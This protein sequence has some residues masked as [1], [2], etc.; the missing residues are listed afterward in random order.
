MSMSEKRPL[1]ISRGWIQAASIV[2][3]IGFMRSPYETFILGFCRG[4][5]IRAISTASPSSRLPISDSELQRCRSSMR[6]R[7][8]SI[9]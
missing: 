1:M 8:R 5:T 7:Y 3:I 4:P 6:L 9:P 2:L